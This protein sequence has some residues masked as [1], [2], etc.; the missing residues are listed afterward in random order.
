MENLIEIMIE[1]MFEWIAE[2]LVSRRITS[3]EYAMIANTITMV[4]LNVEN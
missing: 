4:R 3:A 2:D 1:D